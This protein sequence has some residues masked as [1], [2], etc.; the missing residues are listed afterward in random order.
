MNTPKLSVLLES[1]VGD[2]RVVVVVDGSSLHLQ[3]V[4]D[5]LSDLELTSGL[6][7]GLETADLALVFVQES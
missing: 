1:A 4:F 6:V 2:L 7:D 5:A 3:V